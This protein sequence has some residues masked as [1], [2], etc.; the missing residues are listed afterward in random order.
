MSRREFISLIRGAV[1]TRPL[2]APAQP[3]EHDT[4]RKSAVRTVY[5]IVG[6]AGVASVSTSSLGQSV[7]FAEL[8]GT[9]V[10]ATVVRQQ[11]IRRQGKESSPVLQIDMKLVIGPGNKIMT[12]TIPTARSSA[13]TRQGPPRTNSAVL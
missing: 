5:L 6:L 4:F 1:T 11:W 2:A 3:K 9:V 13:G 10:D 7:T 12:T 8:G